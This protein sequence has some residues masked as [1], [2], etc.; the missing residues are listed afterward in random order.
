MTR[1]RIVAVTLSVTVIG[2]LMMTSRVALKWAVSPP[3]ISGGVPVIP[4]CPPS[5]SDE[6]FYPRGS[7]SPGNREGDADGRAWFS[8]LL[9][10]AGTVPLWCGDRRDVAY[11]FMLVFGWGNTKIITVRRP[12][13][14][15]VLDAVEF[16]HRA[17]AFYSVD[18]RLSRPLSAEEVDSLTSVLESDGFWRLPSQEQSKHDCC[19]DGPAW[20]LEGRS[21]GGYH[22]VRRAWDRNE[23]ILTARL[24]M[25]LAGMT[26]EE[27]TAPPSRQ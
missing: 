23:I 13:G 16:Q 5:N 17:I 3:E 25:Q 6:Y 15:W 11:R 8:H 4:N 9:R 22:L 21:E 18:R 2:L 20:F 27:N 1:Y 10:A 24:F 26:G 14:A 7:L 12:G 19:Y